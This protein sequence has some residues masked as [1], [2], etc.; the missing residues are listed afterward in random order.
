MS[1]CGQEMCPNWSGDGRVCPCALFGIELCA[2]CE[3]PIT[4]Q[5]ARSDHPG[6]DPRTWCSTD[7]RD[8]TAEAAEQALYA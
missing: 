4:R 3:Q 5:P 2:E 1:A 8:N 6:Q 7:C